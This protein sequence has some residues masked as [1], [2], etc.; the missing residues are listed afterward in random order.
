MFFAKICSLE[1][2]PILVQ[3]EDTE[4]ILICIKVKVRDQNFFL[5][6]NSLRYNFFIQIEMF[7]SFTLGKN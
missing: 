7:N 3:G 4:F 6:K 1:D 5:K 2:I